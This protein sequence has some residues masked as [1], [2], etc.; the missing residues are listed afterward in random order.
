MADPRVTVVPMLNDALQ[1][2][3]T[4]YVAFEHP[5]KDR[6]GRFE[7][8]ADYLDEYGTQYTWTIGDVWPAAA[9]NC[10]SSTSLGVEIW[11]ATTSPIT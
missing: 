3:K 7:R 8:Q 4:P 2:V 9:V 10:H 1:A 11:S 6:P 5:F